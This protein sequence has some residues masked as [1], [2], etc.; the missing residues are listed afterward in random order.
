MQSCAKRD[1][2]AEKVQNE[3]D[4]YKPEASENRKSK[5]H[6]LDYND[7]IAD[8]HNDDNVRSQ[9]HPDQFNARSEP[10][11]SANYDS[12]DYYYNLDL[13]WFGSFT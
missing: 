6:E 12:N 2:E 7:D 8:D 13:C 3:R 11:V 9:Q 1:E 5:V 10:D 4:T